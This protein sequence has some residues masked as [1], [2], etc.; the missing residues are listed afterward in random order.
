M[1]LVLVWGHSVYSTGEVKFFVPKVCYLHLTRQNQSSETGCQRNLLQ[2]HRRKSLRFV[3]SQNFLVKWGHKSRF[4]HNEISIFKIGTDCSKFRDHRR[5]K[6]EMRHFDVR[7][8]SKTH[9]AIF[10]SPRHHSF[11]LNLQPFWFNWGRESP[12]YR[13]SVPP[14]WVKL[15]EIVAPQHRLDAAGVLH[16]RIGVLWLRDDAQAK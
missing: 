8:Q 9:I 5:H 3:M 10:T 16:R 11:G 1:S 15:Q 13:S 4:W 14:G 12:G 7:S 2:N 6:T